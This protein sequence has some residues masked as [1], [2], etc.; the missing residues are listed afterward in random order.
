MLSIRLTS[1][2]S[3]GDVCCSLPA[4]TIL[5]LG[6][7]LSSTG[8]AEAEAPG[9][10]A[11]SGAAPPAFSAIQKLE[12]LR[13]DRHYIWHALEASLNGT[14]VVVHYLPGDE[15]WAQETLQTAL[16]AIP[17]L[18]RITGA[19]LPVAHDVVVW[20]VHQEDL[21]LAGINAQ[22]MGIFVAP[23]S[24]AL[25]HE[26]AHYWVGAHNLAEHWMAEGIADLYDHLVKLQLDHRVW[27]PPAVWDLEQMCSFDGPLV[28][29]K[30]IDTLDATVREREAN[31]FFYGKSFLFWYTLQRVHGP[32]FVPALQAWID[33]SDTP[34]D[35]S[36]LLGFLADTAGPGAPG[37]WDLFPGWLV[38]GEY[39]FRGHAYTLKWFLEDDD[40]DGVWNLEEL[41]TRLD[42]DSADTD[43]DG[44][45]DG[46]ELHEGGRPKIPDRNPV[47]PGG[48][49]VLPQWSPVSSGRFVRA[50]ETIRVTA[51][52]FWR[53][54]EPVRAW[55]GPE[56]M[57][58]D[59][60]PE[61]WGELLARV[62]WGP[63]AG[64]VHR[65]GRSKTFV[66]DRDGVLYLFARGFHKRRG[67]G[68]VLAWVDGGVPL[69]TLQAGTQA[70]RRPRTRVRAVRA[71]GISEVA[72]QGEHVVVMLHPEDVER[73]SAPDR[74]LA[75]LDQVYETYAQLTGDLPFGGRPITLLFDVTLPDQILVTGNALALTFGLSHLKALIETTGP[76][77]AAWGI[78]YGL[79]VPFLEWHRMD[80]LLEG[81]GLWAMAELMAT[82][83]YESRGASVPA[84]EQ[85]RARL[86]SYRFSVPGPEVFEADKR[87]TWTFLNALRCDFGWS[88]FQA[89][90]RANGTLD[91]P[92]PDPS[93]SDVPLEDF[94]L[95]FGR[96]A[97]LNLNDR[98]HAWGFPVTGRLRQALEAF[99][100]PEETVRVAGATP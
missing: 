59:N 75:Y 27:E 60:G 68:M 2:G 61:R 23:E 11:A 33:A 64:R 20:E 84:L 50:G 98:F 21:G 77:H 19:P 57:A 51:E 17:V 62:G 45:A 53:M 3:R 49:Q 79:A 91:D 28:L 96:H 37:I 6:A 80:A 67:Q 25:I 8:R 99:P 43:G 90:I 46:W 87:L 41:V 7:L 70:L 92:P 74:T 71:Q 14:R 22:E 16:S 81:K 72:L 18:E 78:T 12:N 48:T 13:T 82:V 52:G 54:A 42:P 36:A 95:A 31:R 97:R 63:R 89:L 94:L 15:R 44:M 86:R 10:P 85:A 66:A 100:P 32:G 35:S 47:R 88:P 4:L 65:I 76:S 93:V 24:D 34:R 55:F 58:T 69:P 26:L 30:R 39:S 1:A 73:M 83:F 29:W 56:G 38:Q 5:L 40:D 9:S